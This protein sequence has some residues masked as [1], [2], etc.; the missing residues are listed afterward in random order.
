MKYGFI[1]SLSRAASGDCRSVVRYSS[2]RERLL[3]AEILVGE[4]RNVK[5]AERDA[6]L[7]PRAGRI[8]D[9]GRAFCYI[10]ARASCQCLSLV[11]G[12]SFSSAS[13]RRRSVRGPR[14]K[15]RAGGH[16]SLAGV[17][18]DEPAR[19]PRQ[20][21]GGHID[22]EFLEQ[23]EIFVSGLRLIREDLI[24]RLAT[25]AHGWSPARRS[26]SVPPST[27][28]PYICLH[29]IGDGANRVQRHAGSSRAA[30]IYR[31]G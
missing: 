23:R 3:D 13:T 21:R 27:D 5:C 12:K 22:A 18:G 6:E 29:Q 20:D 11:G 26:G 31:R 28:G 7:R 25:G 10:D 2:M 9:D 1:R 8:M 16:G 24:W 17:A 4:S 15:A 19:N 30:R 14:R